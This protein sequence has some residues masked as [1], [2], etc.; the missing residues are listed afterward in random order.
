MVDGIHVHV[1]FGK[2]FGHFAGCLRGAVADALDVFGG[3][4]CLAADPLQRFEQRGLFFA[5][6]HFC[7]G[8][9]VEGGHFF[10]I[11]TETVGGDGKAADGLG[12]VFA[13]AG[14]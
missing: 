3:H 10:G 9:L 7:H 2:G 4:A 5:A 14:L 6:G 12:G 11:G 1:D 13:N 8:R